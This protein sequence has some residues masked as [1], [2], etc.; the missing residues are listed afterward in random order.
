MEQHY[1]KDWANP[2]PGEKQWTDF[3]SRLMLLMLL[4][5]GANDDA[6]KLARRVLGDMDSLWVFLEENGVEPTN[7]R[8]ERALRFGCCGA[9]AATAPKAT[10]DTVGWNGCYRSDKS[11]TRDL[12]HLFLYWRRLYPAILRSSNPI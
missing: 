1:P 3:Y 9:N 11:A 12:C 10:R 2:P 8:A 5:E 7:N 6:G 4:F